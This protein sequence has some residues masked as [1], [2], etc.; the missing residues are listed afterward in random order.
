MYSS[1][2]VKYIHWGICLESYPVVRKDWCKVVNN[3]VVSKSWHLAIKTRNCQ[4]LVFWI[5][6][7]V[8]GKSF[9][10]RKHPNMCKRNATLNIMKVVNLFLHDQVVRFKL[11]HASGVLCCNPWPRYDIANWR[12]VH[13]CIRKVVLCPWR[14]IG[15]RIRRKC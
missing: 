9:D 5:I 1:F 11:L 14:C 6:G 3:G 12:C 15:I 7:V 8:S 4:F 10:F 13:V 2:I